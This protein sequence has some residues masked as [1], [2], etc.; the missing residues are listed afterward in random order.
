MPRLKLK[1]SDVS[2]LAPGIAELELGELA[3]NTFDGRLF[4]K[5]EQNGQESVVTIGGESTTTGVV[6]VA[7]NG[8]DANS[9]SSVNAAK[10]TIKSALDVARAGVFTPVTD[11]GQGFYD[12]IELLKLNRSFIQAEVVAFVN[13]IFP[14]LVYNE[15][16][17]GRDVGL[18]IDALIVD[19]EFGGNEESVFAARSYLT[20]TGTVIP[21]EVSATSTAVGYTKTLARQVVRNVVLG[22]TYQTNVVQ[23]TDLQYTQGIDAN[24]RIVELLDLIED[25]ITGGEDAIPEL[26]E[27][28]INITY[29]TVRVASGD[30]TE[31]NPLD[32]PPFTAV[33]GD[34]LRTVTVRPAD[35]TEDLFYVT[36]GD[37]LSD[38][39]FS[40]HIAP[41]AAIAFNPAGNTFLQ[42]SVD[43]WRSPYIQNCTSKTTTGTGMRV[44]GSVA[45]GLRSMVVDSYTQYNEGGIGVH[46]LN[47][48]YAQLVSVFT[49]CCQDA[50][51]AES[52]GFCSITNSNSSFGTYGL[53]ATGVS[54]ALYQGQSAG[55]DQSGTTITLDNLVIRPNVGDAVK[56]AGDDFYYTVESATSM[57]TTVNTGGYNEAGDLLILNKDYIAGKVGDY[58]DST[59]PSLSYDRATCERDVA[60]IVEALG[61]DLKTGGVE[62]TDFAADAYWAGSQSKVLGQIDETADAV[63]TIALFG[64]QVLNKTA[65][66]F[67]DD[68]NL[69]AE[70]GASTVV[71]DLIA[72]LQNAITRTNT[73]S[74]DITL[75]QAVLQ[76]VPDNTTVTFH[77]RSLIGASAHTFEYVGTGNQIEF[78]V[79]YLGGRPIQENEVVEDDNGAGRVNFTSTDQRGDF[80]IGQELV[81]ERATGTISGRTFNRSL[82]AVMTPYI[83]A[84]TE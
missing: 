48:G 9:G 1:R 7:K 50:F 72:D 80:R 67:V 13:D 66:G 56:F 62:N 41:T 68:P 36:H 35:K 79:P 38:M 12:A 46:L 42:R 44:D 78:A 30:Y 71:A 37:Y 47:R 15:E 21:G 5:V 64:Q 54:E 43:D 63:G 29:Y 84:I 82:F 3:L 61:N 8:D 45:G 55:V 39:T 70:A 59:Y 60:L 40:D 20:Y 4:T 18:I 23:V 83:L 74:S 32:M 34:S 16:K 10:R 75:E 73:G 49:I 27:N 33:V 14:S 53:R 57:F 19:L 11:P 65:I 26:I 81:I 58:V 51:L 17:C 22:F 76:I 2:G 24:A 25:S 77:Q 31:A 28:D 69:T 6:Y 52:G